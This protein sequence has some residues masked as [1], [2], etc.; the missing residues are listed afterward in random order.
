MLDDTIPDRKAMISAICD[1]RNYL[2]HY[3]ASLRGRAA[4]GARLLLMVE[5]LK[6]VL[7]ACFLKE[8]GFPQAGSRNSSRGPGRCGW[9]GISMIGSPPPGRESVIRRV[10]DLAVALRAPVAEP[11]SQG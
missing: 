5:V 2:T 1:N 6:L 4:T 7:Q 3:N 9:S 11:L 8:L 10:E